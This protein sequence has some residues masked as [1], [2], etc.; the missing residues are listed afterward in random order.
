MNANAS[1]D[2]TPPGPSTDSLAV[3]RLAAHFRVQ[4]MQRRRCCRH[5]R[6]DYCLWQIPFITGL[7]RR[8]VWLQ[9]P[10]TLR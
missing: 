2:H 5:H 7:R 6:Y 1:F 3:C 9:R 10:G 8:R 4:S